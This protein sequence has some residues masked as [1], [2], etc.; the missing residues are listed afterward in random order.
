MS[1]NIKFSDAV[2]FMKLSYLGDLG[3]E[4][5]NIP[6]GFE[7]AGSNIEHKI[8]K[9]AYYG[10]AYVNH[11]TQQLVLASS[12]T[13]HWLSEIKDNIQIALKATP[14]QLKD[15]LEFSWHMSSLYPEYTITTVGHSLG[16][17]LAELTAIELH[18]TDKRVTSI[19]VEGSGCKS[20]ADRIS[21]DKDYSFIESYLLSKNFYN[22]IGDKHIGNLYNLES[23]NKYYFPYLN[24]NEHKISSATYA[25]LN[26]GKTPTPTDVYTQ[27]Y[28][29]LDYTSEFIVSCFYI[30]APQDS[31]LS[32]L[33]KMNQSVINGI[34]DIYHNVTDYFVE[35]I[36]E[37]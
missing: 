29:F 27:D 21:T 17:T 20:I 33:F 36:G 9:T 18:E 4:H 26:H 1:S 13:T 14:S 34:H 11:E 6:E 30:T 15:A 28:N 7:F 37:L 35:T 2:S 16:A 12:G 3:K 19:T 25:A 10:E 24:F 23:T 5:T 8:N 22:S 32:P 31:W